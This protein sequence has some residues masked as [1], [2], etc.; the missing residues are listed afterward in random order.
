MLIKKIKALQESFFDK[1]NTL[2]IKKRIDFLKKLKKVLKKKSKNIFDALYKDLKKSDFEAFTSET[3][4]VNKELN[5]MI[6]NLKHWSK[7]NRV[8]SSLINFPFQLD[9]LVINLASLFF[10]F[11]IA[12]KT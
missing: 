3:M 1:K 7:P 4:L 12:E 5:I 10:L 2:N 6:N 9:R 11:S 8:S